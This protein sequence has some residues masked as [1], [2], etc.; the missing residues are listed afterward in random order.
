MKKISG[1][2]T[3]SGQM[4]YNLSNEDVLYDSMNE[5]N[6]E[7]Q[8]NFIKDFATK[9]ELD[10]SKISYSLYPKGIDKQG[11]EYS[12]ITYNGLNKD[13]VNNLRKSNQIYVKKDNTPLPMD[14]YRIAY[15]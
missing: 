4:L 3:E 13:D 15:L 10:V 2:F 14:L 11:N 1:V 5:H 6:E 12:L 9:F 7:F 8:Q